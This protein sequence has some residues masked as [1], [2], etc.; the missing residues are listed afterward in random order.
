MA[1]IVFLEYAFMFDPSET[2]GHLYQF[3]EDLFK[4]FDDKGLEVSKISSISGQSGKR[5][6]LIKQKDTFIRE[7]LYVGK[8]RPPSIGTKLR[9][10]AP[11]RKIRAAERDF[12]NR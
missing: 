3:E 12:K 7:K 11:E 6:M 2:W 9:K 1:D 10:I 8:G 5:V 4:F